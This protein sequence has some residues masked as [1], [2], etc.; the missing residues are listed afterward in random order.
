M[1]EQGIQ[2]SYN[3]S[4]R[5]RFKAK[6]MADNYVREGNMAM[7]QRKYAES[8]DITPLIAF[9]FITAL[10]K[11]EVEYYVAPY[12]AD[13]QLA[14]LYLTGKVQLVI[15]EDS[16]LLVFGV[17]RVFFK[18]DRAGNGFEVDLTRMAEVDEEINLKNFT[19]EM[20][21]TC[22]ILSGCDYLDSIKGVGFKK[23]YRLVYE[24]G[25]DLKNIIKK[26]RREGKLLIP[27]DYEQGFE[28]AYLT[29]KFQ[30]VFCPDKL[31][32]VHLNDPSTHSM[33]KLLKNYPSLNFLGDH[34]DPDMTL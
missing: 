29:F 9:E 5:N 3:Y 30:Y 14:Y 18:M 20:F 26:I 19:H 28:K 11:L 10:R 17:K 27:S 15:T 1:R 24:N 7:A 31:E 2:I 4:C 13:A 25:D 12:E 22:C 8:I 6:V 23:A 33:G 21:M 32:L 16:D 34:M